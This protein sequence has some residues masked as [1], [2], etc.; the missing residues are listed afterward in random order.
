M[1][2]QYPVLITFHAL[3]LIFS[4]PSSVPP[5]GTEEDELL[6]DLRLIVNPD[7]EGRR[8]LQNVS[9]RGG[10]A[11][12]ARRRS[13][14]HVTGII[15]AGRTGRNAAIRVQADIRRQVGGI[16]QLLAI[17]FMLFHRKLLGGGIDLPQVVDTA[18]SLG[19][20]TG[21]DKV[22]YGEGRQQADNR[23]NNGDFQQRKPRCANSFSAFH[24]LF[25]IQVLIPSVIRCGYPSLPT[26]S[27][28]LN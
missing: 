21:P 12:I 22:G 26:A 3:R 24:L 11:Q 23:S 8:L 25:H 16:I 20:G 13:P 10:V 14:N 18:G 17:P 19:T 1:E 5:G 27:S 2:V 6:G 4:H 9:R 7:P 28:V 15:A